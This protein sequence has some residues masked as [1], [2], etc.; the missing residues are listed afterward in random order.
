MYRVSRRPNRSPGFYYND[1]VKRSNPRL[2]SEI[3]LISEAGLLFEEIRS[4]VHVLDC[5]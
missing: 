5:N 4:S 2:V 3:R 1:N